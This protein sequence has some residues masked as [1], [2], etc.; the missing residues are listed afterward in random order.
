MPPQ[1]DPSSTQ[2]PGTS[3]DLPIAPA[4]TDPPAGGPITPPLDQASGQPAALKPA[5]PGDSKHGRTHHHHSARV[6][7]GQGAA[8]KFGESL[9]ASVTDAASAPADPDA[10]ASADSMPLAGGP[11]SLDSDDTSQDIPIAPASPPPPPA[12]PAPRPA[13]PAAFHW[14]VA[15]R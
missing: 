15:G 13:G 8:A 9:Q 7:R 4:A 6:L 3:A 2:V 12:A 14:P 1:D 10:A 5:A 11:G